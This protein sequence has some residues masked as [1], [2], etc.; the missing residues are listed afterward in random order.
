M[1]GRLCWLGMLLVVVVWFWLCLIALFMR[2]IV[3][4]CAYELAFVCG[5][6]IGFACLLNLLCLL[7]LLRCRVWVVV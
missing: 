2:L 6:V 1:A 4:L 3:V 5:L 7:S